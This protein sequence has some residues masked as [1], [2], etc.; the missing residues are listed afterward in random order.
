LKDTDGLLEGTL[1]PRGAKSYFTPALI[2]SCRT[3]LGNRIQFYD[4]CKP[5]HLADLQKQSC[6]RFSYLQVRSK[7]ALKA[8]YELS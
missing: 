3:E 6:Y 7:S 2:E 4:V 8:L 5:G 1:P